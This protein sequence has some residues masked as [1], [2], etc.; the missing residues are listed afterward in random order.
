MP[1]EPLSRAAC[2]ATARTQLARHPGRRAKPAFQQAGQIDIGVQLREV[3]A[4]TGRR[5]LD[6]VKLRR[7][8]PLQA[9]DDGR[10]KAKLDAGAEFDP[11]P[12]RGSVVVGRQCDRAA[13]AFLHSRLRLAEHLVSKLHGSPSTSGT[14]R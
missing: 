14:A 9:L 7:C 8:G 12:M 10:R 6:L 3:Q 4:E 2:L 13:A 11:D 1:D 5:D